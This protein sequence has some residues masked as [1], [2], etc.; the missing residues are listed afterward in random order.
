V[1]FGEDACGR[2]Y[3]VALGGG[4][5]RLAQSGHPSGC[6]R[7]TRRPRLTLMRPHVRGRTVT[8]RVRCDEPCRARARAGGRSSHERALAA[9][10]FTT[11]RIV[12]R[13]GRARA[14]RVTVT[15]R[16]R[17]GN[18]AKARR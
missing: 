15:A 2:V 18:T 6:P 3:V 10:R 5:S 14:P 1:S 13:R 7:D 11:L 16:D 9:H 17:A 4:L 12:L 8:V